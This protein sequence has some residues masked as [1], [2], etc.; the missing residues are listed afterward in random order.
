MAHET[1]HFGFEY[2]QAFLV[3]LDCFRVVLE[4][5]TALICE[6]GDMITRYIISKLKKSQY[7]SKLCFVVKLSILIFMKL[8]Q[9]LRDTEVPPCP[10]RPIFRVDVA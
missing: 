8:F 2:R 3:A 7:R 10:V 6:D 9:C 4:A 1:V 5:D